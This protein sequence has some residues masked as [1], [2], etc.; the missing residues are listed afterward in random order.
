[1]T[2]F[3]VSFAPRAPGD[4]EFRGAYFLLSDKTPTDR[5]FDVIFRALFVF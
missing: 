1:V 3:K 4:F 2:K 5:R